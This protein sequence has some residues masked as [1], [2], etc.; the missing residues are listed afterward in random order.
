MSLFGVFLNLPPCFSVVN[1]ILNCFHRPWCPTRRPTS[2]TLKTNTPERICPWSWRTCK[3]VDHAFIPT[4]TF[5]LL[6]RSLLDPLTTCWWILN[7]FF[8]LIDSFYHVK[9]FSVC[10]F[11]NHNTFLATRSQM[12]LCLG[13][14]RPRR[15]LRLI[16]SGKCSFSAEEFFAKNISRKICIQITKRK[17]FLYARKICSNHWLIDWLIDWLSSKKRLPFCHFLISVSHN[18]KRKDFGIESDGQQLHFFLWFVLSPARWMWLR[19]DSVKFK[20]LMWTLLRW[21]SAKLFV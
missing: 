4:G 14:F 20:I 11:A 19:L 9:W 18:R 16:N 10:H 13:S 5:L 6:A 3:D 1:L 12:Y 7:P 17:Y 15:F 8:F 21:K 2:S